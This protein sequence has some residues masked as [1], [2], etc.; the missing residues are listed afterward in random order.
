MITKEKIWIE[1]LEDYF[2]R[3]DNLKKAAFYQFGKLAEE[4]IFQE[5]GRK[6]VKPN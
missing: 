6:R 5:N 4:R 2:D 3:K 1:L